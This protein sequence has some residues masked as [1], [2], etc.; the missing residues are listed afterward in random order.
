MFEKL[1]PPLILYFGEIFLKISSEKSAKNGQKQRHKLLS[2]EKTPQN[3]GLGLS[4]TRIICLRAH[5][6]IIPPSTLGF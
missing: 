1:L 5:L 6:S 4:F 3:R 2:I